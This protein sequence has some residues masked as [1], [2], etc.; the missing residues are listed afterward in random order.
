MTLGMEDAWRAWKYWQTASYFSRGFNGSTMPA[1]RG[2]HFLFQDFKS[3]VIY[4]IR[5]FTLSP[6]GSPKA[7]ESPDKSPLTFSYH[8]SHWHSCLCLDTFSSHPLYLSIIHPSRSS[9]SPPRLTKP[10]LRGLLQVC[11]GALLLAFL[12]RL[13]CMPGGPVIRCLIE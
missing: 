2:I 5:S 1:A 9:S 3:W 8:T 10:S 13:H 11:R 12:L 7:S 6:Q 4:T